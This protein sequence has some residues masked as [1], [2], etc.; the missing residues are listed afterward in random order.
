MKLAR[1]NE[2]ERVK[3]AIENEREE[4]EEEK[5]CLLQTREEEPG[6]RGKP[7]TQGPTD[8]MLRLNIRCLNNQARFDPR[9]DCREATKG[10]TIV[11][12]RT[13]KKERKRLFE[14]ARASERDAGERE[15]C[16]G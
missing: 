12:G 5:W 2:G 14:R 7:A 6:G 8:T 3:T 16:R 4:G 10:R 13:R 1:G 11:K 15:L 9:R